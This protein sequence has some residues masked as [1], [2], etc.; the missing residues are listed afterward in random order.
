[1]L[2]QICDACREPFDVDPAELPDDRRV[3]CPYCGDVN[4]IDAATAAAPVTHTPAA[5]KTSIADERDLL[6]VRPAL[7]RGHPGAGQ[8]RDHHGRETLGG[9]SGGFGFAFS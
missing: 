1:M 7:A 6:V 8:D 9:R 5:A 2:R 4:R 3:A